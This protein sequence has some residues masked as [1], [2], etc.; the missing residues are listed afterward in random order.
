[1]H[2]PF[3]IDLPQRSPR[4]TS[5][6]TKP[7]R[8]RPLSRDDIRGARTYECEMGHS[9]RRTKQN[10][11]P[12]C[13]VPAPSRPRASAPGSEA[14]TVRCVPEAGHQTTLWHAPL[15][16]LHLALPLLWRALS[17]VGGLRSPPC[18]GTFRDRLSAGRTVGMGVRM[19]ALLKCLEWCVCFLDVVRDLALWFCSSTESPGPPSLPQLV[20]QCPQSERGVTYAY[21]TYSRRS[22]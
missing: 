12:R 8:T 7:E 18:T 17:P 10:D 22:V 5:R 14:C 19:R 13:A 20:P 9:Q 11:G 15:P 6:A 2:T 1:M 21:I 16:T 4:P 3:L